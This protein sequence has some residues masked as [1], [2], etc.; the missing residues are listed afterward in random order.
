M[1]ARMNSKSKTGQKKRIYR[2]PL[3]DE[4]ADQARTRILDGLVQVMARN[5][6]AELSVPL[7]AKQ[8]GVSIPSVYRYFPT[9]RHLI[10]A[11]DEYAH[12]KGSFTLDEF[13]PIETPEDIARIVPLTFKRREAIESTLSAAMN[14]RLGFS[15]RRHEF[16]ERAKHFSK[17]LRPATKHLS[18]KEQQWLTD[19]VFVLSSYACVRAFRDYLGLDSE[20]AGK[21]VSW[22][23]RLLTRGAHSRNGTRS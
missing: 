19:V 23:I 5:G 18:R 16:E 3:R 8:A 2:S 4:R 12:K 7:I 15:M 10:T 17:A 11:L 13:G 14:S 1:S 6:I 21:R 9:K 20:E 22:A